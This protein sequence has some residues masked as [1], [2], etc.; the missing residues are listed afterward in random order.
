MSSNDLWQ[1]LQYGDRTVRVRVYPGIEGNQEV[2]YVFVD[3]IQEHFPD[4]TK[5]MCGSDLVSF[6]RD[7]NG[8]W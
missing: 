5:F 6:L 1:Q 3:D 2:P 4:A 7:A 8:N